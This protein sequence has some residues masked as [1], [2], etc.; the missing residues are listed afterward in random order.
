M[1]G[2]CNCVTDRDMS[3]SRNFEC[4]CFW[5]MFFTHDCVLAS[6]SVDSS[7]PVSAAE[8]T[9]RAP[10]HSESGYFLLQSQQKTSS[11]STDH[12]KFLWPHGQ[13]FGCSVGKAV[14]DL[15]IF[16]LDLFLW[17]FF[18]V[19]LLRAIQWLQIT[20]RYRE[21]ARITH[22]DQDSHW[23][24]RVGCMHFYKKDTAAVHWVRTRENMCE[25]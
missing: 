4:Q 24:S 14:L 9:I 19:L 15:G 3:L 20:R 22:T 6:Y 17:D 2:V 11:S 12:E 21:M 8:V 5:V 18:L 7:C 23:G 13:C 1:V 16:V 25:R 10:K